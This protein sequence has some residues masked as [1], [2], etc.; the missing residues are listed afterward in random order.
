M[1]AAAV[2]GLP[3]LE[4][5][6]E[7]IEPLLT[8]S[9]SA[10]DPFLDEVATHL[11]AAGGKRLR[12]LLALASATGGEHPASEADL[13]GGV[14][15]EL[16]HLASLYHDDV[17]D[18]ATMRRSVESVNSRFGN[19]VAIVAGDYLLS[20]S[21]EIAAGLGT[22]IAGLLATTLGRLCQGQVAEVRAAFSVTRTA[23]QYFDAIAGK[24]AALM[25]TSC[26]I[27]A[28]TGGRDT[29][30]VE[31]LTAFGRCFGMVFQL[32]DDVM[33]VVSSE[34]ELGKPPGQDLAEG[35]YTLPVLRAL[36]D[37]D[38]G[39]EL[40]TLLG[41]ALGQPERDKAR[42]MVAASSGIADTVAFGRRYAA[43]A[44]AATAGVRSRRLASGLAALT[45]SLFDGQFQ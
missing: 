32:R 30:E 23:D 26:R 6:L 29:E 39:P 28:L 20:R 37:R 42:S 25:A 38:V 27:G 1:D 33:D 16:V 17:I 34:D 21:A 18:E 41:Q 44:A 19:L 35:V 7:R 13:L 14:A 43:D 36:E 11:I 9:V 24:T 4:G 22:E 40:A 10:G 2:L 45:D 8:S 15:V 31:A 5:D 3:L 12:P